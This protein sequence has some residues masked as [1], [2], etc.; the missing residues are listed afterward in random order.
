M[1]IN[2]TYYLLKN[3]LTSIRLFLELHF[4]L[5]LLQQAI[6]SIIVIFHY[7]SIYRNK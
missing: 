7:K 6:V 2:A 4:K 5:V 1:A 3:K